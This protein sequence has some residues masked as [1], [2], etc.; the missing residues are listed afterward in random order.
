MMN[1]ARTSKPFARGS[2]LAALFAEFSHPAPAVTC[3]SSADFF[4]EAKP[5]SA[6]FQIEQGRN[7]FLQM[8]ALGGDGDRLGSEAESFCKSFNGAC[9]LHSFFLYIIVSRHFD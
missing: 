7:A 8:E 3:A 9:Q 2:R 6:N 5:F 4:A 1:I